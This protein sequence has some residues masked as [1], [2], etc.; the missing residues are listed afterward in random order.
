MYEKTLGIVDYILLFSSMYRV[1]DIFWDGNRI[2]FIY[3]G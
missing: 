2:F 3:G 1:R